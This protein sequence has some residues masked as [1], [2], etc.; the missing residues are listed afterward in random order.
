VGL[1]ILLL[2]AA[3]GYAQAGDAR[4][5]LLDK[6]NDARVRAGLEPLRASPTLSATCSSLSSS[7]MS[8]E[9]FG[10]GSR[11]SGNR[12]FKG[13]GEALSIHFRPSPNPGGTVRRWMG[14]PTHRAVILKGGANRVGAGYAT[15]RFRGQRATIWVLQ[16]GR[17]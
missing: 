9:A 10:H 17:L 12:R 8:R 14:S 5:A 2:L 15:G 4:H 13:F 6:V 11:T 1:V 16:V 7:L 3:P